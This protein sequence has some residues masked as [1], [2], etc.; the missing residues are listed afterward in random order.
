MHG[1]VS[2]IT[3]NY[4]GLLFTCGS[5]LLS[6][7]HANAAALTLPPF[8]ALDVFLFRSV[9]MLDHRLGLNNLSTQK[10]GYVSLA[11]GTNTV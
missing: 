5:V 4:L 7:A 3:T 6:S 11:R 1:Q 8:Q 2:S 9:A 10:C